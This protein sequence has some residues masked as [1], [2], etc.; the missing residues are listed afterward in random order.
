MNVLALTYWSYKEPLIQAATL[1]HLRL[2]HKHL[3][4]G[5]EISL[6]TF[7]KANLQ[8]SASEIQ[9]IKGKLAKEGIR[10]IPLKYW[11][12]GPIASMSWMFKIFRLVRFC[13]RND[14]R[15][16][17]AFASTAGLAAHMIHWVTEIPYVVDSFEPHAESMV[18]NGSWRQ[19]SM[20]FKLLFRFEKKQA[21]SAQ[22][23]L[24][25]SEGMA[26]YSMNKY[27]ACPKRFF[28]K[29]ACVDL[30][31]FHP[32]AKPSEDLSA[33]LAG[34]ITCVY[35]GKLGGIYLRSEVFDFFKACH[36]HWGDRFRALML[37]DTAETEINTLARDA[38]IPLECLISRNV[39]HQSVPGYLALAQFAINPV[40][41][42][43]SKRYCTSIKDGE[44]WAMGLPVVIP[45][46]I[47]DDSDIIKSEGAGAILDELT[48]RAYQTAV[49]TI[50]GLIAKSGLSDKIRNLAIRYRSFDN[51]NE[52]Y[53]RLYGP[54]AL[55]TAKVES[56]I[57]LIYNSF[58]DPL[59]QNLM[60]QYLLE[61]ARLNPMYEFELMTFEQKRYLVPNTEEVQAELSKNG[62]HWRPLVYHSGKF[63]LAKK[64]YD[65][66]TAVRLISKVKKR[67]QPKMI[68]AFAN[69]SAAITVILSK[70]FS[71]PMM[72]YSFEPHSEFLVEFG[73][74]KRNSLRHRIL[75]FL[76][77][78]AQNQSSYIL[79][80]TEHMVKRLEGKVKAKVLRAP[81]AVDPTVFSFDVS[82]RAQFREQ[83]DLIDKKV[84]IYVGKFGG[85][86][87]QQEIADF[88]QHMLKVDPNWRLVIL[89]PDDQDE[90]SDLFDDK[91]LPSVL[92]SEAHSPTEVAYWL[93]AADVGLSA[94]PPYP[95]QKF[96]SPVKVGEYLLC[97]LPYIT[98]RNVS[99]DDL[100]AEKKGVGLVVD[101]MSQPLS[102]NQMQQLEFLIQEKG[103]RDKCR[104]VGLEYRSID[105]VHKAV[106][107][108]L[109]ASV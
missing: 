37:T 15:A 97:G 85:I 3:P 76:E 42:V 89:T 77:Q 29:P 90:V 69:T 102:E 101:S 103:L 2:I 81:S 98:C 12:F 72:I 79:T 45:A 64:L 27:G 68:I 44:Y 48:P 51:A 67:S 6:V 46:N 49:E 71:I 88:F 25:T 14:V 41:P 30:D 54:E 75:R 109:S 78:A 95:S 22:A 17:H 5:S 38:G 18:E 20:A 53:R 32:K 52:L 93:S 10:W 74:W 47:S 40:M 73:I 63:M 106:S 107:E 86:Y 8:L 84:M 70:L 34:K 94:I 100:W 33:E 82:V 36:D 99:E 39:P 65:F 35:A 28:V 92:I 11:Q 108:A 43:P 24:A 60:H 55:A 4:K 16:I 87:Y 61:Q 9:E 1:P 83:F 26:Q 62:I 105:T 23:V 58:K 7:E 80:G 57:V 96:R 59:Y 13:R 21:R 19:D 91:T 56:F 31:L 66:T 50:E 104:S